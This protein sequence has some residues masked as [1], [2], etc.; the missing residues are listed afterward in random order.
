VASA[1]GVAC[2]PE[3]E[4]WLR[5]AAATLADTSRYHSS[6]IHPSALAPLNAKVLPTWPISHLFPALDYLR[7]AVSHPSGAEAAAAMPALLPALWRVA[8]GAGEGER[9]AALLAGR[10][11]GNLLKSAPGRGALLRSLPALLAATAALLRF[12][13]ASVALGASV[14]LHNLARALCE[15][16]VGEA[17]A[18]RAPAEAAG[19]LALAGQALGSAEEDVRMNALLA[20]GT[21]LCIDAEG[22]RSWC[23]GARG[24]GLDAAAAGLLAGKTEKAAQEVLRLLELE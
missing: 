19:V 10:V 21:L 12:P 2:T 24:A 15:G 23:R 4:A 22:G 5:D 17:L 20:L 11:L 8:G 18:A 9:P 3:E 16:G 1:G 13:H 14:V 7:V 6:T